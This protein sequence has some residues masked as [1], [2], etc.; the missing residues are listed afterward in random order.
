MEIGAPL[1]TSVA[2]RLSAKEAE[3]LSK[4][5][6]ENKL[7]KGSSD[8][9]S[10]GKALQE[11]VRWCHLNQIDI[12][13]KPGESD[14]NLLKMVEQIHIAIPNLMYLARLQAVLGTEGKSEEKLINARRQT[15]DYLNI[16]C[17]DFQNISYKEVR[18]SFNDI[19]MKS[20]PSDK[21]RTLW[22]LQS[23]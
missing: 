15:I 23:I 11:L 5:A 10:L 3:Y 17:G 6:E 22:K 16:T 7:Y 20:T 2:I 9:R 19:G 21:E 13:K 8:E 12:N 1:M 18:F 4:I 14:N